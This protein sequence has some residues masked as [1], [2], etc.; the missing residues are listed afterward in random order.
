MSVSISVFRAQQRLSAEQILDQ[1]VKVYAEC[2]SYRDSGTV[3]VRSAPRKAD[4]NGT[5]TTAFIRPDQFRFELKAQ[6]STEHSTGETKKRA[7]HYIA[8]RNNGK[9]YRFY[10]LPT[11]K[12]EMLPLDLAMA[13]ATGIS[14][15][16]ATISADMLLPVEFKGNIVLTDMTETKRLKDAQVNGV[17][18][19][20]IKGRRVE[21]PTTVW[22]H[23][24]TFL[25]QKIHS[26]S[27]E[28]NSDMAFESTTTWK[29]SINQKIPKEVLDFNAPKAK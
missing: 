13:G 28:L 7:M 2:K 5:F 8:S 6:M 3:D 24:N 4:I 19:Y 20:C 25:I 10:N 12:K 1:M 26:K 16:S 21:I 27:D 11:P 17:D 18:C 15:G 23:K 22:I 9:D 14:G 29:S